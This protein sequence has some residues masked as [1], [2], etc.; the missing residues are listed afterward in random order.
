MHF[1]AIG[2]AL[3]VLFQWFGGRGPAD[4]EIVVSE[5]QVARLAQLFAMQWQ[6]PP[7]RA[8]L[9]N[10]IE[11][12]IREEVLYREAVAMGLDQDDTVVR[13][14]LVQKL[15]FLS[16][17]LVET[18]PSESELRAFFEDNSERFV[19]PAR[20]SFRHVY[21]NPDRRGESIRGDAEALLAG[22][23][24]EPT[25]DIEELGDTFLLPLQFEDRRLNELAGLFGARF[26]DALGELEPGAWQ[27]PVE[28]GYGLHL[29]YVEQRRDAWLPEFGSI[30]DEVR[31][32]LMAARRR[33]ADEQ[34]YEDLRARYRIDVQ[35]PEALR[36]GAGE[37]R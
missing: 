8:E 37:E 3:F 36:A 7:T 33:E 5:T 23:R 19:E 34:M 35:L 10:L 27:G 2:A 32:E 6:R 15:E 13:R 20:L 28:S 30:R 18:D 25:A 24:A 11:Q 9:D 16:Q 12:H 26:A 1:L 17:D 22:L 29:V 14:R 31:T 21:L 4:A